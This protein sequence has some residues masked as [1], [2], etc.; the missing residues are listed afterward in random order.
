MATNGAPDASELTTRVAELEA[1]NA[2]LRAARDQPGDT[3]PPPA[4]RRSRWSSVLSA[5]LIIVGLVLGTASIV[6]MYAKRQ[7]TDTDAFVA[8]L[9]PLADDPDVQAAVVAGANE[10]IDQAVDI[11]SLTAPVFDGIADLDLPRSATTSLRLLQGPINQ[12]LQSLAHGF[13]ADVIASPTF[14][15]V[16]QSSL[17]STHAQLVA[18]LRGDAGSAVSLS[19]AG[20]VRL[21]LGPLLAEVRERLVA[22]EVMFAEAIPTTDRSIV[23]VESPELGKLPGVYAAVVALGSWLPWVS[24]ALLAVGALVARRRRRAVFATA[25]AVAALMSVLGIAIAVGRAVL[26]VSFASEVVTPEALSAVVVAVTDPLAATVLAIGALG[27]AV[28]VVTWW[29]GPSVVARWLRGGIARAADRVRAS[30]QRRGVSTGAVGVW[31]DRNASWLTVLVLVAAAAC[32]LF[33]RP[34]AVGTVVWAAVL[35]AVVVLVLQFV[36]RP[37]GD[38]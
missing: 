29:S 22:N 36:R 15:T 21:E 27:A 34:L 37:A 10:A 25:V 24:L 30:A 18:T 35:G 4:R 19:G 1:E 16:W 32:V 7:L 6:A 13:V 5:A 28:A 33:I 11:P 31:V 14:S 23:L 17:R 8:M 26:P 38:S 2:R 3:A 20:S 12:G 9:A